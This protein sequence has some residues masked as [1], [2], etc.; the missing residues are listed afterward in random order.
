MTWGS[1][2]S[3]PP[4]S[5]PRVEPCCW[6]SWVTA[7]LLRDF[8]FKLNCFS[9]LYLLIVLH[10]GFL[11]HGFFPSHPQRFST[12]LACMLSWVSRLGGSFLCMHALLG[13][14]PRQTNAPPSL[15]TETGPLRRLGRLGSAALSCA[16]E[17]RH[18]GGWAR[19]GPR[20]PI[21]ETHRRCAL[22]ISD[23]PLAHASS[24]PSIR[25]AARSHWARATGRAGTEPAQHA[26][27]RSRRPRRRY[28]C[29]GTLETLV[30]SRSSTSKASWFSSFK[31]SGT[32][33]ASILTVCATPAAK[34]VPSLAAHTCRR[35]K[36]IQPQR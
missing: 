24:G 6:D 36:A 12:P 10:F 8:E 28:E 34:S 30:T 33:K 26:Q 35:S 17:S 2:S 1:A 27:D 29:Q 4:P 19:Q 14:R 32:C 31:R 20:W 22:D 15:S 13:I 18:V 21:G 11:S 7:S 3:R 5:W 16:S 23:T 9:C 25:L